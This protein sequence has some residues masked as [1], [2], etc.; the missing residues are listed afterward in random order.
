MALTRRYEDARKLTDYQ[1]GYTRACI[2]APHRDT[3]KQSKPFSAKDF[4][5]FA[6]NAEQKAQTWQEQLAHIKNIA[7][8]ILNATGRIN[9]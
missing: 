8:P 2:L 3:K 1:F 7:I 5:V 4:L 9:T 6:D